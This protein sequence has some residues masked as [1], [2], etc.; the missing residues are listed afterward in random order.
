MVFHV[1]LDVGT[2]R[3]GGPNDGAVARL[4]DIGGTR[5][6]DRIEIRGQGGELHRHVH[7][8]QHTPR[9]RVQASLHGPSEGRGGE[10]FY[11]RQV[12]CLILR[13]LVVAH[14]RLAQEVQRG[15]QARAADPP[16]GARGFRGCGARDEAATE[17]S[18]SQPE[19]TG[20]GPLAEPA[21]IGNGQAGPREASRT[22]RVG[23]AKIV[24]QVADGFQRHHPGRGDVHEP[25]ELYLGVLVRRS[26]PGQ[27]TGGQ[28]ITC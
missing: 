28:P 11:Q 25:K 22:A 26:P 13:R 3:L 9:G 2:V 14:T 1:D 5:G 23:F 15:G 20:D 8:R 21:E 10:L 7:A 16:H 19:K 17:V 4:H 27:E 12:S 18:D 6:I 24:T